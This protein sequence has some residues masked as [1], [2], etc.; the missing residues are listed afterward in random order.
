MVPNGIAAVSKPSQ[1]S[2]IHPLPVRGKLAPNA[3]I[4][5]QQ[6]GTAIN[7]LRAAAVKGEIS[8][9]AMLRK[10]NVLPRNREATA[11]R[12]QSAIVITGFIEGSLQRKTEI[13]KRKTA[14]LDQI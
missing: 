12:P 11:S 7:V 10:R 6:N 2:E 4:R 8:V 1:K 9:M 3:R 13:F 5:A 14:A